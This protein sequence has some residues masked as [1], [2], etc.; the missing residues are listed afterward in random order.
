MEISWDERSALLN[1]LR[2]AEMRLSE[3]KEDMKKAQEA[4]YEKVMD[5]EQS[6]KVIT[7]QRESARK[8]RR[9]ALKDCKKADQR[10]EKA[11]NNAEEA[12]AKA[13][14]CR[15]A[16]IDDWKVSTEGRTFPE[17]AS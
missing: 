16:I 12:I 5:L 8:R 10:A 17:D 9:E 14:E 3:A 7:E 6:I 15:D 1:R 13:Q 4:F 2:L 11:Q